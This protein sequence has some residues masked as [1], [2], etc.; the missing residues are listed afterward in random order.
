MNVIG[1]GNGVLVVGREGHVRETPLKEDMGRRACYTHQRSP[2][3]IH[4]ETSFPPSSHTEVVHKKN[5]SKMNFL[6]RPRTWQY[7]RYILQPPTLFTLSLSLT[8]NKHTHT[9]TYPQIYICICIQYVLP[10]NITK[11]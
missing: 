10:G 6:R 8:H 1:N 9:H 4:Q 11:L 2:A 7:Q 3:I 5:I